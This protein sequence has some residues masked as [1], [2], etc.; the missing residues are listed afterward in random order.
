VSIERKDADEAALRDLMQRYVNAWNR[1]DTRAMAELFGEEA[2]FVSSLGIRGSGRRGIEKLFA[3]MIGKGVFRGTTADVTIEQVR[4]LSPNVGRLSCTYRIRGSSGR[5]LR[6]GFMTGVV[7]RE[8]ERWL[9]Q[10]F[11]ATA[12]VEA[13]APKAA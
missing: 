1:G 4:L 6:S 9:F 2:E 5:P 12:V 13:Q 11:Q 8:G 7:M 3:D 10:V